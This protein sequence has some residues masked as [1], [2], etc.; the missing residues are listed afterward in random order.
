MPNDDR[1]Y[2]L[3]DTYCELLARGGE[4]TPAALGTPTRSPNW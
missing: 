4:I 2:D 1:L 3:L